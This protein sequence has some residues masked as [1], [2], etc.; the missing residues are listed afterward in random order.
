MSVVREYFR[1]LGAAVVAGWDRFWF[2]PADPATYCLIRVFAGLMLLYTH[3]VWTLEFDAFFGP[4]PWLPAS[5]YSVTPAA[6]AI[7][8]TRCGTNMWKLWPV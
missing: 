5:W 4:S 6:L 7:W 1:A 3:A 8:A 2:T